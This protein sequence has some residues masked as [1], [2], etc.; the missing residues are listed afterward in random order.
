MQTEDESLSI[1]EARHYDRL[2][3]VQ[4]EW[5]KLSDEERQKD[6]HRACAQ[7]F[8]REKEK[9]D[10]TSAALERAE[11]EIQ[12]L[13]SQLAQITQKQQRPEFTQYPT[14]TLPISRATVSH[15][16][17]PP[18]WSPDSFI[19]KWKTRIQS[20]RS[21]QHSLPPLYLNHHT[22]ASHPNGRPHAGGDQRPQD[23]EQDLAEDEDDDLE[24]APGEDD[25]GIELDEA[26]KG[27]LDPHLRGNG[28]DRTYLR[29]GDA[30]A[31]R[32]LMEL[33]RRG[34]GGGV[35]DTEEMSV[36]F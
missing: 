21:T 9:H 1:E 34:E 18:Q 20:A 35:M 28:D 2:S 25:D 4:L 23:N 26:M 13:R 11:Q 33:G 30:G 22:S 5:S 6:W 14:S 3:D 29:D 36:I 10:A 32:M 16:S 7:A 8:A 31:G 17:F 19:N 27:R 12:H 24:D 15:L